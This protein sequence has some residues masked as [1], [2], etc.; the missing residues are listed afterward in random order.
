MLIINNKTMYIHIPKTSGTN[1]R[2]VFA[3]SANDVVDYDEVGKEK[4]LS[5]AARDL[6]WK[7]RDIS[8]LKSHPFLNLQDIDYSATKHAP[9]WVWEQTGDW[10]GQ[11][12]ITI[13]RNPYTRAVSLYKQVVR[14][15]GS[16]VNPQ[17]SFEE[18]LN[19]HNMQ[20]VIDRFP[21]SHKTPQVDYLRNLKGEVQVDKF[22]KIETDMAGFAR[23]F[24]LKGLND[25][26]H[27]KA[28]YDRDYSKI[29]TDY[30]IN[31]VQ[32]TFAED[33]EVFGYDKEPFWTV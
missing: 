6:F 28:D 30:L 16:I 18:F 31:W 24:K 2:Y 25:K 4:I 26:K 23:T 9:L 15:F 17:M 22:Y 5:T 29:Y 12:V 33:F 11:K 7:G 13:V 32:E 10:N 20:S 1:L 19:N 27:N 3:E 21:H 14:L 8:D